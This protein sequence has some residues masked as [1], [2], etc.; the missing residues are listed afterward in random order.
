MPNRDSCELLS[1]QD[2]A[3]L[4][5]DGPGHPMHIGALAL[6]E[7]DG[8]DPSLLRPELD[9]RLARIPRFRQRL[10][11]RGF[12]RRPSWQEVPSFEARDHIEERKLELRSDGAELAEAL[13]GLLA[14][15]L[16]RAAPLWRAWVISGL[17]QS[18][19]IGVFVVVHHC[20][21]DGASGVALLRDVLTGQGPPPAAQPAPRARLR[22]KRALW[23]LLSLLARILRRTTPTP[24]NGPPSARREL[25]WTDLDFR[26]LRRIA[27]R[28]GGSTNDALLALVAG[29][30]RRWLV[31]SGRAPE[32]TRLRA[33]CPVDARRGTGECGPG[34]ALGAWL[35]DLP[36]DCAEAAERFARI[37]N[38]TAGAK[39]GR[40]AAAVELLGRLSDW[41]PRAVAGLLMKLAGRWR[42]Y[43][44]VVSFAPSVRTP[45]ALPG[46][47]VMSLSAFAPV[48]AGQRCSV[49]AL[50][51]G[52]T[53][54]LGITG[55][56]PQRGAARA[57]REALEAAYGE[58]REAP[59]RPS[60]RPRDPPAAR[61]APV[62]RAAS[63]P[64]EGGAS[65]SRSSAPSAAEAS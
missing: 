53:L 12:G 7:L 31:A 21:V 55:A 3:F 10:A 36:V 22:P 4:A 34:N 27:T 54:R 35:V 59:A 56:W 26:G 25:A 16:D 19:R 46:A 15:P 11:R 14:A 52:D 41:I 20:L 2:A 45:L 17:D 5:M 40:S 33:F 44:I 38:A 32:R 6:F 51:Y 28:H 30:L 47:R 65:P 61:A 49:L 62:L 42:A 50:R 8:L 29:A 39:R 64:R 57:M 43:N 60:E 18:T 37:R 48:F 24:L 9:R 58:L 1:G 13:S 23:P 63:G